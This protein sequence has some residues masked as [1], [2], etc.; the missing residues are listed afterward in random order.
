[1]IS[2]PTFTA[3]NNP[4]GAKYLA[5]VRVWLHVPGLSGELKRQGSDNH[6]VRVL[7]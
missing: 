5:A 3:F 1:M 7:G 4:I 2:K 6:M